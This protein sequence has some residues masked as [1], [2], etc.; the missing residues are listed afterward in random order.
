MKIIDVVRCHKLTKQELYD[1]IEIREQQYL[2]IVNKLHFRINNKH[3][4]VMNLKHDV[5]M[6]KGLLIME[7]VCIGL[8]LFYVFF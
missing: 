1:I 8:I 4:D 5:H 2:E 3:L 7:T 6:T